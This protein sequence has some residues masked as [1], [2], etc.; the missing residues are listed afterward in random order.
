MRPR[1]MRARFAGI[2]MSARSAE[3]AKYAANGFLAIS[4]S[5]LTDL[6]CVRDVARVG[7]RSDLIAQGPVLAPGGRQLAGQ[8][9]AIGAIRGRLNRGQG[10]DK[11]GVGAHPAAGLQAPLGGSRRRQP[12]CAGQPIPVEGGARLSDVL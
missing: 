6:D 9:A 7:Q 3:L 4:T 5:R 11:C 12:L 10:L 2:W 8:R 1:R